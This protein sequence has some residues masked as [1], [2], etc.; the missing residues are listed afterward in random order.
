M[1]DNSCSVCDKTFH[2]AN[3]RLLTCG[4]CSLFVHQGCYGVQKVDGVVNWFCRKCESQ[5]RQSKIVSQIIHTSLLNSFLQ[6]CELCPIKEGAFK[7]SSGARCGWAH[8]LCAFFIPEVYFKDPDTMDLIMLENVPADRFGRS[9]IFCERNQRSSQANHG[10]CIQCAWKT[11]R[12]YFHVTCAHAAGLLSDLPS[13]NANANRSLANVLINQPQG[14][15]ADGIHNQNT[16]SSRNNSGGVVT[17]DALFLLH[18]FCST[19]HKEKFSSVAPTPE[20]SA[21]QAD[22]MA[23]STEPTRNPASTPSCTPQDSKCHS[24]FSKHSIRHSTPTAVSSPESSSET[25]N[26]AFCTLS[27]NATSVEAEVQGS[28][29]IPTKSETNSS[30]PLLTGAILPEPD[31]DETSAPKRVCLRRHKPALSHPTSDSTDQSSTVLGS[32][33]LDLLETDPQDNVLSETRD[34]EKQTVGSPV[35]LSKPDYESVSSPVISCA[36]VVSS[37]VSG[38][39]RTRIRCTSTP[40]SVKGDTPYSPISTQDEG[41]PPSTAAPEVVDTP[42]AANGVIS[43]E[44]PTFTK[45]DGSSSDTSAQ[46]PSKEVIKTP[47]E[48]KKPCDGAKKRRHS[49]TSKANRKPNTAPLASSYTTPPPCSGVEQVNQLPFIWPQRPLPLRGIRLPYNDSHPSDHISGE[50]ASDAVKSFTQSPLTTMQDLLEWQWDQAGAL[51]MQQASGTDVVS[52]LDCLHQLKVENDLLEAK[53]VRLQTRQEHLRSVNARLSASLATMEA[54]MTTSTSTASPTGEKA[55][56]VQQPTRSPSTACVGASDCT[57]IPTSVQSG[58][59]FVNPLVVP[60]ACPKHPHTPSSQTS[61]ESAGSVTFVSRPSSSQPTPLIVTGQ[62]PV[63]PAFIITNHSHNNATEQ[64]LSPHPLRPQAGFFPDSPVL[65]AYPA[66]KLSHP[67]PAASNGQLDYQ[68]KPILDKPMHSYTSQPLPPSRIPPE[69]PHPSHTKHPKKSHSSSSQ[70]RHHQKAYSPR[71]W[72]LV[73]PRST[74]AASQP[75]LFA[76]AISNSLQTKVDPND[77]QELSARL[78]SAI[79]A[80]RPLMSTTRASHFDVSSNPFTTHPD[81]S[82]RRFSFSGSTATSDH[83]TSFSRR[84]TVPTRSSELPVAGP[85]SKLPDSSTSATPLTVA[86]LIVT[87]AS[88]M[89]H[90]SSLHCQPNPTIP[91]PHYLQ[92]TIYLMYPSSF[93]DI[94]KDEI[95]STISARILRASRSEH[96]LINPINQYCSVNCNDPVIFT[97]HSLLSDEVM[98]LLPCPVIP[99]RTAESLDTRF[100]LIKVKQQCYSSRKHLQLLALASRFQVTVALTALEFLTDMKI[101]KRHDRARRNTLDSRVGC[102]EFK[103]RHC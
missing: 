42:N 79:A 58:Q 92:P 33:V 23:Q 75:G 80:R 19:R 7:R 64:V 78:S 69:N 8:M 11:C 50:Q 40:T 46:P 87:A 52:L 47:Q 60:K 77:L 67:S 38:C 6:R 2:N 3:N 12:T 72:P 94:P 55:A 59:P 98:A 57:V 66:D 15:S 10:V 88:G 93:E 81:V 102:P 99:H 43:T 5:V 53:L 49:G 71:R 65:I 30:E 45:C 20:A 37:S 85:L 74:D 96:G 39:L 83:P 48:P 62:P 100:T 18:G 28:S 27:A 73:Q 90:E 54:T 44:P 76:P 25:S 51:L 22:K 101:E 89:Y 34:T 32:S 4:N 35:S 21:S 70:S 68:P 16:S 41:I 17:Y 31:S 91:S 97:H 103:P 84:F 61:L 13:A 36:S 1:S 82:G 56:T 9:C 24:S 95:G 86:P 63:R 26:T 29:S 14:P